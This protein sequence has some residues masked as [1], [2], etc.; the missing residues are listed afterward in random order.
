MKKKMTKADEHDE[1]TGIIYLLSFAPFFLQP[2][3]FLKISSVILDILK[4]ESV[5]GTCEYMI[6]W[7]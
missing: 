3:S 2:L 1:S 4:P 5:F 6:K 7:K